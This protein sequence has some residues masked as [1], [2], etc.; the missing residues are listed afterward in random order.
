MSD[1]NIIITAKYE[2]GN[3]ASKS[4]GL[5]NIGLMWDFCVI[6]T[7]FQQDAQ[8]KTIGPSVKN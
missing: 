8:R 2:V 1:N 6:G 5:I 7:M 3:F 4:I